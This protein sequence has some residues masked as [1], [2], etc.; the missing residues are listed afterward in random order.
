MQG[1]PPEKIVSTV[2][3]N[4]GR[5]KLR[6]CKALVWD[7]GGRASLRS[8]WERYY[9]DSRAVMFCVD[10]A[11]VGHWEESRVLLKELLTDARLGGVPILVFASKADVPGS[12]HK[13]EMATFFNVKELGE[14][15]ARRCHFVSASFIDK[16]GI[17]EG[18][19][20]LEKAL[21][22]TMNY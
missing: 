12:K 17:S 6:N 21:E 9:A 5:L 18:M 3:C 20:W 4:V 2:G 13:D 16:Q 22:R 14:L 19:E 8:I 11:D 15:V 7:L 10:A 1:L